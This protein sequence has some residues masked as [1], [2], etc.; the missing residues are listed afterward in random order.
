MCRIT[1]LHISPTIHQ[2]S[3]KKSS[4]NYFRKFFLKSLKD[5]SEIPLQ[6]TSE[7]F[8]EIFMKCLHA[9]FIFKF[10]E[11]F[12]KKAFIGFIGFHFFSFFKVFSQD[13]FENSSSGLFGYF[14]IVLHWNSCKMN[15]FGNFFRDYRKFF[16]SASRNFIWTSSKILSKNSFGQSSRNASEIPPA[17]TSENRFSIRNFTKVVFLWILPEIILAHR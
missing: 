16:N 6:I 5:F 12:L 17:I 15:Y 14:F 10:I 1:F 7:F 8:V 11:G 9:N 3:F 2:D 13:S 4:L